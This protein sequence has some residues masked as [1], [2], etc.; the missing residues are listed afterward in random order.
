MPGHAE[1]DPLVASELEVLSA[2]LDIPNLHWH[3]V[4]AKARRGDLPTIRADCQCPDFI[5]PVAQSQRLLGFVPP[6][7]SRVPDTDG[8]VPTARDEAQAVAAEH[9]ALGC[10]GVH[11]EVKDFVAARSVPKT[12][13]LVFASR[14]D[15]RAI[16]AE[17]DT[18]DEPT[19]SFEDV[20]ALTGRR[21]PYHE[22]PIK[23]GGDKPPAIRAE[24]HRADSVVVSEDWQQEVPSPG[25]PD[26]E[27][28]R[29]APGREA[30]AVRAERNAD[31]LLRVPLEWRQDGLLCRLPIPDDDGT[32]T[33]HGEALAI[34][35]ER[36]AVRRPAVVVGT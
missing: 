4:G 7:G 29:P 6:Q 25:I 36:H 11:T 13:G 34:R 20:E 16:G 3:F 1:H 17:R 18:E 15:A 23:A 19:V 12:H 5:S 8:F 2:G 24:S 33:P 31:P 14:R 26:F 30:L 28:P 22:G 9:D 27:F 10:L 21:V 32:V 35:V